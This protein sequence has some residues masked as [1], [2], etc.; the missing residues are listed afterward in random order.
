MDSLPNFLTHGVPLCA[1]FAR[2]RSSA[3]NKYAEGKFSGRATIAGYRI[4]KKL[5]CPEHFIDDLERV[6]LC[7]A[8][9]RR[10]SNKM[11]YSK[12][13][14]WG[15][16]G[17]F[18]IKAEGRVYGIAVSSSPA[19]CGFS[20]FWLTVFGKEDPLRYCGTVHLASPS[21][22]QVNIWKT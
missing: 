16:R 21:V 5:I 15:D 17:F 6:C 12:E 7:S 3:K 1:R 18:E 14:S 11:I 4:H 8:L 10:L 19:V 13:Q 20:A 9:K 2:A 22:M